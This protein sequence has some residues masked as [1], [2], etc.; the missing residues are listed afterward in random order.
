MRTISKTTKYALDALYVLGWHYGEGPTRVH[1]VADGESIP[2]KSYRRYCWSCE[3][4]V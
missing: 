2:L 1:T 4:G 3:I